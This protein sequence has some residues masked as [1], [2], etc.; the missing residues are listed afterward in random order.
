MSKFHVKCS[1]IN[2]KKETT[3][4]SLVSH[5][6]KCVNTTFKY[7]CKNCGNG[8]N[9]HRFCSHSC[10]AIYWN[11]RRGHKPPKEKR[12]DMTHKLFVNGQIRERP[13]IRRQLTLLHGYQCSIC[14]LSSWQD[15]PITLVVDHING[16]ASNNFPENLRLLCPNCNSQTSTFS[17]RNKG[18]GRK[19]RGLLTR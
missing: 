11:R 1:C 3:T 4:Q 5:Y 18:N 9:N 7:S 19:A 8:T 15:K 17:G 14:R 16:D 12:S 6:N 10:S 2:C 13:T